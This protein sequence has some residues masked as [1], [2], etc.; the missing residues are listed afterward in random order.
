MSFRRLYPRPL[1]LPGHCGFP[2]FLGRLAS[3]LL[4]PRARLVMRFSKIHRLPE[5]LSRGR[6]VRG[7]T[8]KEI[9]IGY[10]FGSKVHVDG[11]SLH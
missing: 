11:L 9:K 8:I 5:K 4:V 6:R 3:S 7:Q 1:K 2:E 10:L